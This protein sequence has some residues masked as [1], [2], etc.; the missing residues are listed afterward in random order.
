MFE[1]LM[2]L[3]TDAVVEFREFENFAMVNDV[4]DVPIR[5]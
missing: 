4:A 3:T 2:K 5:R 1:K